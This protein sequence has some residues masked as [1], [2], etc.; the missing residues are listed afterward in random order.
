MLLFHPALRKIQL[1]PSQNSLVDRTA[2][3]ILCLAAAVSLVFGAYLAHSQALFPSEDGASALNFRDLAPGDD[4]Q[5]IIMSGQDLKVNVDGFNKM[6]EKAIASDS[7]KL[8]SL[9]I[10]LK[11]ELD[12]SSGDKLSRD[13]VSKAREIEKLARDVKTRMLLNPPMGPL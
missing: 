5:M 6:R 9:A 3:R 2:V 4:A 1:H 10:A 11:V 12:R 7:E 8:L 13:A